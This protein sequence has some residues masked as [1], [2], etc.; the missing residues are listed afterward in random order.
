MVSDDFKRWQ[1]VGT[2]LLAHKYL[3]YIKDS[4]VL[5]DE[6]YDHAE[7]A[8]LELGK[9]VGRK[10]GRMWVGFNWN[11]PWADEAIKLS[12]TLVDK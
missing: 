3:Y 1:E 7:K 4:P 11:H 8:W 12:R 2:L 5:D 10:E 9:K 6:A